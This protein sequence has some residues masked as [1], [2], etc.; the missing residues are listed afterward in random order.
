MYKQKS[1]EYYLLI[2]IDNDNLGKGSFGEIFL[3]S[4]DILHPVTSSNA[5][6]V[7]KIEPHRSGPLFVEIHCLMKAGKACGTFYIEFRISNSLLLSYFDFSFILIVTDD[8]PL[9][10]GMPTY[11]ASGGHYFG[12]TRY[13]FL[14]LPRYDFDLN[15]ITKSRQVETK[16]ILIIA[17]QL[18]DIL[19]HIHDNG[20]AH[21]DIKAENIMIG[22][23]TFNKKKNKSETVIVANGKERGRAAVV[24][25]ETVT[26]NGCRKNKSNGYANSNSNGSNYSTED[27]ETDRDESSEEYEED[28][29]VNEQEE[30]QADN[31]KEEVKIVEKRSPEESDDATETD[32]DY[33]KHKDKDFKPIIKAEN[34]EFGGSNPVRSCRMENKNQMY[35]D[36]V[37][38]H[39]LRRPTKRVNYCENEPDEEKQKP[40]KDDDD[41]WGR[42]NQYLKRIYPQNN[43][44]INGS[45]HKKSDAKNDITHREDGKINERTHLDEDELLTE[46][47]IHLIDFG[48]ALKFIDSNGIHRPF[49]MDQRRAHDGTLEFTSRDA[50]MGAHSR[51]SDL[52]CLA[53]NLIYWKEGFLPW[54]N[55]KIMNQPEQVHRMKEYFMTDIK[56]LYKKIYNV[57]IPTFINEFLTH[58][59]NLAYHDR[60]NYKL[61]KDI[62]IKEFQR[63]GYKKHEMILNVA[64]LRAAPV[65][66]PDNSELETQHIG[67]KLIDVAKMMRMGMIMPFC[68]TPTSHNQI[69][70]KNLRSKSIQNPKKRRKK[71]SW[72]E[73]LSTDPDQIARQRAEKEFEREQ[74][75]ETPVRRYSGNPTYAIL[76]VEQSKTKCKDIRDVDTHGFETTIKGYTKPMMDVWR[77]RQI[78]LM[79]E[80]QINTNQNAQTTDKP[81][82]GKTKNKKQQQQIASMKITP[83]KCLSG[84]SAEDVRIAS[85]DDTLIN[86]DC[87]PLRKISKPRKRKTGLRRIITPTKKIISYRDTTKRRKQVT[88]ATSTPQTQPSPPLP[89]STTVIPTTNVD[90]SDYSDEYSNCSSNIDS[91]EASQTSNVTANTLVVG[92]SN[93]PVRKYNSSCGMSSPASED[94]SRDSLN[95][96]RIK[97]RKARARATSTLK[98]LVMSDEDSRDTTDYSPVKTRHK[99]SKDGKGN[100]KNKRSN[101]R[102][103]Y[104]LFHYFHFNSYSHSIIY[105]AIIYNFIASILFLVTGK[106][107]PSTLIRTFT[108]G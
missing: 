56:Q 26:K 72:T 86:S 6:Y 51:R 2:N 97:T 66:K 53:Y 106:K 42:K 40:E 35:V 8:K 15:S 21:S 57:P 47:R 9:P 29:I 60:P 88:T 61:C 58:V 32:S 25:A 87:T 101:G 63:L 93:P 13:R 50:H 37:T 19:E 20:Y 83:E 90:R 99:R 74:C 84:T 43:V 96:S 12:S 89:P 81:T 69:S 48:L 98:P 59:S 85:I 41:D 75:D 102:G 44:S 22:K 16:N 55:E 45:S 77:K 80:F 23:C 100:R 14:I 92:D 36:M 62:F 33:E 76:Q 34:I 7:V 105:S 38:S 82:N 73:I 52:E 54:K 79:Q 64:S 17:D 4:D 28:Q 24:A 3:A 70:P 27:D 65:R 31:V 107:I 108:R 39:Y 68:E 49:V 18:I 91:S 95:Y 67:Q 30:V 94:D 11:I 5:K 10:L 103:K 46:D 1:I 104:N 78:F 71:F